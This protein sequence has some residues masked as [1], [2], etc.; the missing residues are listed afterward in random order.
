V[1]TQLAASQEGLSSM[2][3]VSYC[4]RTGFKEFSINFMIA[5]VQKIPVLEI[6][7]KFSPLQTEKSV[8]MCA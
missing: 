3:L 8:L 6:F 2:K 5:L 7:P 4:N 1:A